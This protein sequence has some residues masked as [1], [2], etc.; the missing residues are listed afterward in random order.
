M[1]EIDS[2][3]MLLKYALDSVN[4]LLVKLTGAN[5]DSESTATGTKIL[6]LPKERAL[7]QK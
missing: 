4:A 1:F 7:V 3:S 5:I 6:S 2:L